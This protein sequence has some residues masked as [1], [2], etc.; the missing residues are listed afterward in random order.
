MARRMG[1]TLVELMVVAIIVA[2]LASVA[3]PLM[4]SNKRRAMATE[5]ESAMGSIRTALRVLRAE[6]DVYNRRSDGTAIAAAG[7]CRDL[8]GVSAPDLDGRYWNQDCY[9]YK[10]LTTNDYTLVADGVA[11]GQTVGIHIEL[12]EGGTF[13]R[14]GLF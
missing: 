6:T 8:P 9:T 5:A 12:T 7:N 1:F 2:I 14:A 3:V 13:L 10:N 4:A 11:T